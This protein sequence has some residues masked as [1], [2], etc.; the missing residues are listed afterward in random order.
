MRGSLA[1]LVEKTESGDT[2]A[3]HIGNVNPPGGVKPPRLLW[4][5]LWEVSNLWKRQTTY[6]GRALNTCD[7]RRCIWAIGNAATWGAT[8][9]MEKAL[10][11]QET[12]SGPKVTR[13]ELPYPTYMDQPKRRGHKMARDTLGPIGQGARKPVSNLYGP[14]IWDLISVTVGIQVKFA[15]F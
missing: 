2:W 13:P 11:L 7:R 6:S 15:V 8:H 1:T 9:C 4:E 3:R 14:A 5:I 12:P 10:R